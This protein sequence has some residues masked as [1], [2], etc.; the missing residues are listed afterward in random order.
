M[1]VVEGSGEKSSAA[2]KSGAVGGNHHGAH[3]AGP[4]TSSVMVSI[5]R[6]GT[7]VTVPA[8]SFKLAAEKSSES[9]YPPIDV[10]NDL[11]KG[12]NVDDVTSSGTI[13]FSSP[14]SD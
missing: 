3:G 9:P 1:D 12:K 8:P 10:T 11:S 14:S 5:R 4:R 13:I 7:V 6:K 2:V